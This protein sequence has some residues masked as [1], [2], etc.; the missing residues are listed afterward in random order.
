MNNLQKDEQNAQQDIYHAIAQSFGFDDLGD[1]QQQNVVEKMTESVIKRVLVNVYEKLNE[2]QRND[3]EDMMA[4]PEAVDM[5]KIEEF[6]RAHVPDYDVIVMGA[7]T[8]LKKHI[9]ES[10]NKN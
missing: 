9:A 1:I 8:E 10:A 5:G 2:V 6:M 4:D 3:L 7:I